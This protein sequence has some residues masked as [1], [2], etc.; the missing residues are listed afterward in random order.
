MGGGARGVR[1]GEVEAGIASLLK[2]TCLKGQKI[3]KTKTINFLY[4]KSMLP[5]LSLQLPLS[6]RSWKSNHINKIFKKKQ[7]DELLN[8]QEKEMF[9]F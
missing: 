5:F 7:S 9:S 2:L 8:E 6:S 4:I 3:S 1:G